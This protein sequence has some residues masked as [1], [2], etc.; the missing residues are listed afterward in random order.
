MTV[1]DMRKRRLAAEDYRERWL[2]SNTG[3]VPAII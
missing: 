3:G 1:D 2:P